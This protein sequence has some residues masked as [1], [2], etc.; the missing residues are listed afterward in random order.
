[1][2][3]YREWAVRK[4]CTSKH[5]FRTDLE[6]IGACIGSSNKFGKPF[7]YYKCDNCSGYHITTKINLTREAA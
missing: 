6:A 1:M 2:E 7:R 4:S 3:T 5:F